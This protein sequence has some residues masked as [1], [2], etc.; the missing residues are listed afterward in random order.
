[1]TF[2]QHDYGALK[3]PI[4]RTDM[5][6][7][8]ITRQFL[9]WFTLLSL[10]FLPLLHDSYQTL[11]LTNKRPHTSLFLQYLPCNIFVQ[12]TR[13]LTHPQPAP[14]GSIGASPQQDSPISLCL[15]PLT[16]RHDRRPPLF[17]VSIVGACALTAFLPLAVPLWRGTCRR[18]AV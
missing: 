16:A 8:V 14:I 2:S 10:Y 1:M 18:A 7:L 5:S 4:K 17:H 6:Q 12:W 11:A 9:V 3:P 13:S 15:Q